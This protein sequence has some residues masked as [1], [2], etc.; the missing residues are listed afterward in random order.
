MWSEIIQWKSVCGNKKLKTS[1]SSWWTW[2]YLSEIDIRNRYQ[3][4][5]KLKSNYSAISSTEMALQL[6]VN[7]SQEDSISNLDF[8]T[9]FENFTKFYGD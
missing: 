3:N 5:Y 1:R 4:S 2:L 8:E 7:N 6:Y 9:Y